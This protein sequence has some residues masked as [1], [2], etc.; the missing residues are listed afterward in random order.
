MKT[1]EFINQHILWGVPMLIIM[2]GTGLHMTAA[3]K[4]MIFRRFGTVIKYTA[5]TIFSR[6]KASRSGSIT[7]F[8]AVS[9]ALAATVGTG[10][11]AGVSAAIA[12]GGPGAVFWMW[13]PALLGMVTKYCEVT[14]AVAYRSRN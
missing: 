3:T 11:I 4:G 6:D 8:Q 5:G 10:N 9:T 2:L 12:V 14:L 1:I 13:I 7:P